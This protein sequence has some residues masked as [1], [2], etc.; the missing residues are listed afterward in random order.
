V[1]HFLLHY[2]FAGALWNTFFSNV[3]LAWV[4]PRRIVD[5]FACWKALGV[6]LNLM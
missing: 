4:M 2:E 6:G 3:G 5:I 1:D